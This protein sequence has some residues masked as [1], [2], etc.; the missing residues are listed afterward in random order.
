M[1]KLNNRAG[2]AYLRQVRRLLPCS[3]R[4]KDAITAALRQSMTEFLAEQPEADAEAL[5]RRFG[6]P[7]SVAAACLEQSEMPELL[8][9]LHIRRRLERLAVVVSVIVLLTWGGVLLNAYLDY[10]HNRN[11][12][13]V[14][15]IQE[16]SN[17]PDNPNSQG[18][19][20]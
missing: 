3:R 15:W 9:R 13:Y 19:G 18:S 20:T 6:A 8:R 12:H 1:E 17:I 2:Q 16:I 4:V 5:C 7:E 11:G 10:Q 14:Q